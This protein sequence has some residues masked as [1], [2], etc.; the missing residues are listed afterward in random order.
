MKS[1]TTA[2]TKRRTAPAAPDAQAGEAI[3]V[4]VRERILNAA[5]A[6]L[7]EEGS[8]KTTTLAV[9]K[10]AEVSRGAL[11]YHFPTHA[12]LLAATVDELVRRN[13]AS[14]VEAVNKLKSTNE[15][16]ELAVRVLAITTAQP[17]YQAEMELWAVSRTYPELRTSLVQAER[18]ARKESERV[19]GDL[20][21]ASA[22]SPA[23][24]AVMAMTTEFMRG[25]AVSSVLRRNVTKRQELVAQW[26]RAARILSGPVVLP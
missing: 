4:S 10:R 26:V 14:V 8:A 25:L 7:I 19:I 16:V 17:A 12:A 20:F 3:H 9:Q 21:S 24:S 2:S 13:E 18:R 15:G 6:S 22:D 23:H 5:V 1:T 11:L